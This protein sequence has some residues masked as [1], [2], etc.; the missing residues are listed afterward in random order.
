MSATL[1]GFRAYALVRGYT[2]PAMASDTDADAA[3]ARGSDYV[4][5]EYVSAFSD[6]YDETAPNVESAIYE[7]ALAELDADGTL[8][9]GSFWNSVYTPSDRKVLTQVDSI[10]WTVIGGGDD[11]ATPVSSR[12]DALLRH[13]R[14]TVGL[15]RVVRV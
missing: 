5:V 7:A 12:I 4:L 2:A 3:L 8:R 13:Y 9:P 6:D 14:G 10:Q 11:R 1:I 15:K